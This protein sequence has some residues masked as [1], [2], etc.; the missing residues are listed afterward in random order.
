[1]P[2]HFAK[3]FLSIISFNYYNY[4][5]TDYFYYFYFIDEKTKIIR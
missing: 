1:M 2:R 3:S 4:L 5:N